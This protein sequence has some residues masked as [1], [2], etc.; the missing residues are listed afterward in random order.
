ME[1]DGKTNSAGNWLVSATYNSGSVIINDTAKDKVVAKRKTAAPGGM[2]TDPSKPKGSNPNGL[3]LAPDEKTLYVTS[4]GT[5]SVA[6]IALDKD[7]DDSR[8]VGLIPTAWYPTSVSVSKNGAMLY[9]VNGKSMPGSN[10]KACR[11]TFT[12]VS[13]DRPCAAAAQYILQLEKGGFALIPRPDVAELRVLTQRV[14]RNNH[15]AATADNPKTRQL[16]A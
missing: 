6:V 2:L 4:G 3:A 13:D 1:R 12:T 14:A 16:F 8:V 15:F 11:K 5:N 10:P 7:P 9:V